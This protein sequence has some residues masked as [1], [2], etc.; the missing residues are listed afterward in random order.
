MKLYCAKCSLFVADITGHIR[1]GAV[2]L[3]ARCYARLQVA[4]EM[5]EDVRRLNT[6]E[7][8]TDLFKQFEHK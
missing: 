4:D 3:C 2:M 7:F 1:K 6:P 5:A 8:L